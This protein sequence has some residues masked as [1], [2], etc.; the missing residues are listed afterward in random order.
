MK[1]RL[2]VPRRILSHLAGNGVAYLA[3]FF[4]L[5][6]GA[7]FAATVALPRNSVGSL[8]VKDHSL[9]KKDFKAGQIPA[10]KAGA[11]GPAGPA[12]PAGAAGAA[13]PAGPA[14]PSGASATYTVHKVTVAGS[15][16]SFTVVTSVC[17]S[18]S[19]LVSGGFAGKQDASSPVV[20]DRPGIATV[21]GA[22][23]SVDAAS[24]TTATAWT[25]VQYTATAG[26]VSAYAVC[27]T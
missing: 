4:A 7:A 20:T 9:L 15:A 6:G 8:Q 18:G 23:G 5:S 27:A 13:G 12:G 16:A 2:F 10:G 3:L 17:P 21:E 24:G 1:R 11:A 14:G 22:S 19:K 25:V 26:N